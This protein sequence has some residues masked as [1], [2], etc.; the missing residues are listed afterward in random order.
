MVGPS[1]APFLQHVEFRVCDIPMTVQETISIAAL[2]QGICAKLY[3]LVCK[4]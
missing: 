1:G 4:T 2:F 3:K